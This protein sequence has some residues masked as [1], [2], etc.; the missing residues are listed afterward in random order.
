MSGGETGECERKESSKWKGKLQRLL[1]Y[2]AFRFK[3]KQLR[4]PPMVEGVWS[5]AVTLWQQFEYYIIIM[6]FRGPRWPICHNTLEQNV[7]KNYIKMKST[8]VQTLG[9]I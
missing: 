9:T 4:T 3:C 1:Y 5:M 8:K 7:N 2:C 6:A